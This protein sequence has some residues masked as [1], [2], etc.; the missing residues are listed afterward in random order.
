MCH[1]KSSSEVTNT[2]PNVHARI[3]KGH[4]TMKVSVSGTAISVIEYKKKRLVLASL[5]INFCSI[6]YEKF[7]Q[8]NQGQKIKFLLSYYCDKTICLSK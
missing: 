5:H 1:I 7:F 3:N 6:C 4:K 8:I 2:V